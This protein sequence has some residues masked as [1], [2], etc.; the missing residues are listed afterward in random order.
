[1]SSPERAGVPPPTKKL[2]RTPKQEET[3]KRLRWTPAMLKVFTEIRTQ[4]PRVVQKLH[5][6]KNKSWLTVGWILVAHEFTKRLDEEDLWD[7]QLPRQLNPHQVSS[8]LFRIVKYL[9]SYSCLE[10][11]ASSFRDTARSRISYEKQE[12]GAKLMWRFPNRRTN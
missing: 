4:H 9:I 10:S 2:R 11:G 6:A 1:M 3:V 12:M 5:D 7:G 8:I